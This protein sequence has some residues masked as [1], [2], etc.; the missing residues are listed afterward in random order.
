MCCPAP[1]CNIVD[2][3]RSEWTSACST[4]LEIECKSSHIM[5]VGLS[6]ALASS[7][8]GLPDLLA[9]LLGLLARD[10]Q[11][12][13]LR[14]LCGACDQKNTM[15][16]YYCRMRRVTSEFP[17]SWF[18]TE[19]F[20]TIP[21]AGVQFNSHP[22]LAPSLINFC[23]S[24][25]T[26][27][28]ANLPLFATFLRNVEIGHWATH[29]ERGFVIRKG[30]QSCQSPINLTWLLYPCPKQFHPSSRPL[31]PIVPRHLRQVVRGRFLR[32]LQKGHWSTQ[33]QRRLFSHESWRSSI[34]L[35]TV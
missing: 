22:I 15:R 30:W 32:A 31:V 12:L 13:C 33:G 28:F 2:R 11:V 8:L 3:D 9:N 20:R 19:A 29:A 26:M 27:R 17:L 6:K 34:N 16:A 1:L 4:N 35:K 5:Y 23:V 14:H 24:A 18:N 21:I 7:K 25:S 10:P